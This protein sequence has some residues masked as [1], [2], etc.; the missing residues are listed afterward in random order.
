MMAI[1]RLALA[2]GEEGAW[3]SEIAFLRIGIKRVLPHIVMV[4][5][6]KLIKTTAADEYSRIETIPEQLKQVHIYSG[7]SVRK[8]FNKYIS[9]DAQSL[10]ARLGPSI[11]IDI[12]KGYIT[13][14]RKRKLEL[15][16]IEEMFKLGDI[17]SQK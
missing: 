2:H 4:G 15:Q 7:G 3:V 10:M 1:F 16:H 5:K 12:D 13:F 6:D 11:S 17:L 14:Y 8:Q 9:P